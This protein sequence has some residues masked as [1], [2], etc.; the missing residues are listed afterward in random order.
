MHC[1]HANNKHPINISCLSDV[2]EQASSLKLKGFIQ[3]STFSGNAQH[4]AT[5]PLIH[6]RINIP[7]ESRGL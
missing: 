7:L 6:V 2:I 4:Q 3:Y 5:K 1:R